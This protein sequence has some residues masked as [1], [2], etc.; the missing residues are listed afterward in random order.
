METETLCQ[1]RGRKKGTHM[2]AKSFFID[3]EIE[4]RKQQRRRKTGEEKNEEWQGKI[5]GMADKVCP[6][7]KRFPGEKHTST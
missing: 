6:D 5:K 4:K 1:S 2:V 3:H 7:Y